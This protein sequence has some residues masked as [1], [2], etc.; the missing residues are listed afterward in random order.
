MATRTRMTV[1]EYYATAVEIDLPTQLI[2]GELVISHPSPLHAVLQLRLA[3]AFGAWTQAGPERGLA[4]LPTDVVLG[5]HD[6]YAPDVLWI[7]ERH[8][9]LDLR[10]RLER[11]PDICVEI[12][13]P[14]TWRY[15]VGRKKA[16]YEDAGLPELW[17]V[18]DQAETVLA[19]RRSQ[20]D[21]AGFDVALELGTGETLGSP[22][23]PGFALAIDALFAP[24]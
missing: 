16:V 15:D 18:D 21:Q 6:A 22:Q 20:S 12:R 19:F 17:L 23:L 3:T 7:A 11:I 9:P 1:E 8:K 2:D 5:E 13:S 24:A 4:A 10:V 14:S